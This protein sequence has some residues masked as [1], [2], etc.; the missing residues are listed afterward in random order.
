MVYLGK[1]VRH[2]P[3]GDQEENDPKVHKEKKKT[4]KVQTTEED[5]EVEGEKRTSFEWLLS[6]LCREARFENANTPKEVLKVI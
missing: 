4:S 1:V 5:E 2:F 3:R 6:R